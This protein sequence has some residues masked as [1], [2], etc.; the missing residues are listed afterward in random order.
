LHDIIDQVNAK[1]AAHEDFRDV[2]LG[3][4]QDYLDHVI[5]IIESKRRYLGQMD[6]NAESEVVWA[7]YDETLERL[8]DFG[9]KLIRLDAFAYL[10]KK[11]GMT[12]FFNIPGTWDYLDRLK[13]IAETHQLTLLPEIH[14]QY[15]KQL[16]S[17][18]AKAGYPIY[19][20][21]LPGLLLDALDQGR[22]TYLLRWI[23]EI[24]K[25][26]IRTINMLGCHDGIPVLDLD[27]FAT[28]GGY[29]AG[30]LETAE[31]E[32]IIE[33]VLERGGRVKNLFGA[34]GKKIAYYQVNATYFSALGEDEQ[35][36]RLARAIQLFM[37]GI[38]Q[39]WYLDLFAGK[40]D[41]M[42]A[43]N[44]GTAGHKEINRTT[45]TNEAVAAGL[46]RTVVLD[47]LEMMRL[48][49][50]SAAFNGSLHIADTPTH[51]LE[52]TWSLDDNAITLKANL[53]N[54]AFTINHRLPGREPQIYDYP[55]S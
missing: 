15:G 3:P 22:N 20:F 55:K 2:D 36:L 35:K 50:S 16:H 48:R 4:Y 13:T 31:I 14:A 8:A 7:F 9:A 27:G 26:D 30:L 54:K 42:A 38:P 10:H 1:I 5:D 44:G 37:P 24:L 47:Q 39:V 53:E 11:P 25:Q 46:E 32:A 45:L 41:Y 33:R 19:D 52:M 51:E 23:D 40:N 21:F 49:N 29:Q 34:D 18:V 17:A 28:E 43:D 6:L 12:N